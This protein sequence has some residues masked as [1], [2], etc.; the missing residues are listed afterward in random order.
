M[1]SYGF[2]ITRHVN[3]ELTNRYWNRCVKLIRS[4]YPMRQIIIIDDNSDYS[5]VKAD[6]D[7]KNLQIIQSEHP[8]RGELLPFVYFLKH[9]WFENA[10][11][12]HDSTFIHTH[13]PFE[14]MVNVGVMP[15]WNHPYDGEFSGNLL[16]IANHLTN[17]SAVK[18]IIRG[19]HKKD[20]AFN[21]IRKPGINLCFGVQCMIN[22][23]FLQK[24]QQKYHITNLVSA[25]HCRKDRCGLERIMGII[26]SIEELKRFKTQSLFGPIINHYRAFGYN[27]DDYIND[28]N[29]HHKVYGAVIKVWSGR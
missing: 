27:Y 8:K 7:Y 17:A 12:I 11:I 21:F 15:L 20:V 4:N 26:F 10:I 14:T 13:I 1:R 19:H 6:F 24:I 28:L 3:S 22:L 9:Q 5:F 29:N 2:I 23:R 25:I 18:S 16:R